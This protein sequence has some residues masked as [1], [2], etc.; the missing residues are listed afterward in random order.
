M[1]DLYKNIKKKRLELGMTQSELASK[2]GYSGKSS[3]AKIEG[4][5]VDLSES[6]IA[7]FAEALHTT[8][9]ELMGWKSYQ[10]DLPVEE[11]LN[12]VKNKSSS[13]YFDKEV[14]EL[15]QFLHDAPEYKVL[16]DASRKVKKEDIEFVKKMLDKFGD[17]E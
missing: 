9:S 13:Y 15:A 10:L 5:Y 8:P 1:L 17:N 14:R 7:L 12:E 11:I 4:G 6:K 3:I 16:F 2:T